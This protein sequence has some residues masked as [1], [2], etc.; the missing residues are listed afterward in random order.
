MKNVLRIV[1]VVVLVLAVGVVLAVKRNGGRS[2]ASNS[3]DLA[4]PAETDAHA[5][6]MARRPRLVSLGAG[7]C[8]PCKAM[9]PIRES[10]QSEYAD[11]LRVEYHDVW[12]DPQAGQQYG[13]RLIPTLIYFDAEG[14]ELGRTEGYMTKQQILDA[15]AHWG[16]DL[17]QSA[18]HPQETG[19]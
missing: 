1:A 7:K 16:V 8:V 11:R 3:P 5:A 15:F 18:A 9:E 17:S 19:S 2:V 6:G 14:H 10:L 12:N 4:P 13:I